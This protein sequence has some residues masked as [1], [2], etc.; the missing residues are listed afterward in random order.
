[1][2]RMKQAASRPAR[3]SILPEQDMA[4][5]GHVAVAW[6]MRM[7]SAGGHS[8]YSDQPMSLKSRLFGMGG[9][10][11]VALAIT[12]GALFT[13]TAYRAVKAPADLS[14]FTMAPPAA[15]PEPPSEIPPGPEQAR[16]EKREPQ[17]EQP[18]VKPPEIR[19]PGETPIAQPAPKPVVDPGP[20]VEKSMAPESTPLPPAQQRSNARPT[21]EGLVL[22]QPLSV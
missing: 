1:M 10:A 22:S 9:V 14:L 17:P 11:M 3:P 2:A 7:H 13:W 16:K 21:W 5:T 18:K 20:P 6:P 12:G 19:V 8:R 4:D 15:P